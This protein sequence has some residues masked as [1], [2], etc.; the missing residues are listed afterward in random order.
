MALHAY[1]VFALL[2]V[3]VVAHMIVDSQVGLVPFTIWLLY[4]VHWLRGVKE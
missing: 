3:V 2:G 4:A 1:I